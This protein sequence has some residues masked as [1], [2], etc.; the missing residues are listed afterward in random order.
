M[1]YAWMLGIILIILGN[2]PAALAK[3]LGHRVGA[4]PKEFH[5]DLPENSIS[6]LH[7]ALLGR[8]DD[9][10]PPLQY[11]EHFDY[12]P[13]IRYNHKNIL[14]EYKPIYEKQ[15]REMNEIFFKVL[16]EVEFS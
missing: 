16:R 8:E 6:A 1:S 14:P 13:R 2:S 11:H 15:Q 3:N 5:K 9:P 7:A 4:G 10:N 12:Y